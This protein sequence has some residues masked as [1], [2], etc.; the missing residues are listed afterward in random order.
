MVIAAHPSGSL[1]ATCRT[2]GAVVVVKLFWLDGA[3]GTLLAVNATQVTLQYN[4]VNQY[5]K[6][7]RQAGDAWDQLF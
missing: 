7:G 6:F 1:P 2:Y 3:E 4:M 5:N